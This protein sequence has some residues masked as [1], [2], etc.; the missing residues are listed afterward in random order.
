MIEYPTRSGHAALASAFSPATRVGEISSSSR[1]QASVDATGKIISDTFEGEMRRS[2]K[3]LEKVLKTAG[4][5]LAHV[6]QTRNYVRDG[7]DLADFNR[8]YPDFFKEPFP[9]RTTITNCL[10]ASLRYEIECIAVVQTPSDLTDNE[11]LHFF[12]P[13]NRAAIYLKP[14]FGPVVIV[15]HT[16]SGALTIQAQ[17]TSAGSSATL[18]HSNDRPRRSA[19]IPSGSPA[20]STAIS[21]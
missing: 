17:A 10:S 20:A 16:R 21:A 13:R 8:I 9:A 14:A 18:C 2:I 19:R 15:S 3:N 11:E 12:A 1:G 5:D 4:S 7:A 6:V